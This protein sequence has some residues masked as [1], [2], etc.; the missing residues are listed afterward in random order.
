MLFTLFQWSNYSAKDLT[1]QQ[2]E[3]LYHHLPYLLAYLDI[4]SKPVRLVQEHRE[5]V[6]HPTS[7]LIIRLPQIIK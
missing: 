6:F 4:I 2:H 5:L 3:T 7:I 1:L